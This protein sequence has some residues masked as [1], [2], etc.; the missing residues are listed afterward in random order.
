MKFKK[1][2]RITIWTNEK[3]GEW[4]RNYA[5]KKRISKGS[6]IREALEEFKSKKENKRVI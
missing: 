6:I 2:T 3:L 4:L 1:Q 5:F